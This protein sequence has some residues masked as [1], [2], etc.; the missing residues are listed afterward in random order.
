MRRMS[1]SPD[2]AMRRAC[3]AT[4]GGRSS[5]CWRRS[6]ESDDAIERR[7]NLVAHVCEELALRARGHVGLMNRDLEFARA[8]GDEP[9]K[10]F[11]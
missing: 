8:L 2:S 4:S 1:S 7:A 9:L 3:E 11:R 5:R 6:A 10:V